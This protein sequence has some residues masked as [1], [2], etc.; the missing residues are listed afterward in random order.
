MKI[1]DQELINKFIEQELSEGEI[2]IFK[3]KYA[4]DPEFK[5]AVNLQSQAH[6]SMKALAKMYLGESEVEQKVVPKDRMILRQVLKYAAII[7]P[8]LFIGGA[9]ERIIHPPAVDPIGLIASVEKGI[10]PGEAKEYTLLLDE[11]DGYME[12]RIDTLKNNIEKYYDFAS[13]CM[14]T[15]R[16]NEAIYVFKRMLD[17]NVVGYQEDCEWNLGVC[18]LNLGEKVEAKSYFQQIVQ[19]EDHKWQ[20][21]AKKVMKRL[22]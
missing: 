18:Y 22:K 13:Y 17:S 1:H 5:E 16:F 3:E 10:S 19:N 11:I 20:L 14:K 2:G 4:H 8:F 6:I 9:A 15:R 12:S 7:V 21:Q